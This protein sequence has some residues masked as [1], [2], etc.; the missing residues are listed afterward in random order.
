MKFNST[1]FFLGFLFASLVGFIDAF[2]NEVVKPKYDK[3]YPL[4]KRENHW[5]KV[6]LNGL[7]D[8]IDVLSNEVAKVE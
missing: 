1:L 4:K 8:Y 7:I 2:G 5:P 3:I 6:E